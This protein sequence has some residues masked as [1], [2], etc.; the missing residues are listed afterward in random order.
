MNFGIGIKVIIYP[1]ISYGFIELESIEIAQNILKNQNP[2]N[3]NNEEDH[4][5]EIAKKTENIEEIQNENLK[6]FIQKKNKEL[7][8][9]TK[10]ENAGKLKPAKI[11]T[12]C[13][14]INFTN[15]GDRNI[16]TIF[17]KIET[18]KV[19]Q[20]KICNFPNAQYKVDVPG[21]YIFEDFI[22]ENEENDLIET[23]D[24]N[25][26][27][28]L[29]NRRVQH[30]GY[31]FIYGA[32]VINKNKKIG[33]LPDFSNILVKSIFLI[34]KFCLAFVIKISENFLMF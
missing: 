25:K 15:G 14:N 5:I 8:N 27:E 11:K 18:G 17:S 13:H 29:T 1:G 7:K 30:Y 20:N 19:E 4:G 12:F 2:I 24:K 6:K 16:F 22:N 34:I 32:N 28:K 23:L 10:N 26:W 33:E 21:L 3:I 31:E 9:D